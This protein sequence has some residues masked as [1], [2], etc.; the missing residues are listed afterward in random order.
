M[1]TASGNEHTTRQNRT[2]VKPDRR[3]STKDQVGRGGAGVA[4]C[5][6]GRPLLGDGGGAGETG[7]VAQ[8]PWPIVRGSQTRCENWAGKERERPNP[9]QRLVLRKAKQQ[10]LCRSIRK[11][12]RSTNVT[13]PHANHDDAGDTSSPRRREEGKRERE[14]RRHTDAFSR[15]HCTHGP[16]GR[17]RT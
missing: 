7:T 12:S 15:F 10:Q 5:G 2:E 14:Q 11:R 16:L 8:S 17:L 3:R 13:A 4:L 6:C 9:T 1:D